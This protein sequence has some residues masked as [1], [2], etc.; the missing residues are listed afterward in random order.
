MQI[1]AKQLEDFNNKEVETL[2][3]KFDNQIDDMDKQLNKQLDKE[4]LIMVSH[5]GKGKEKGLIMVNEAHDDLLK[6]KLKILMSKQFS[7]LTKYLGTM[8]NQVS[9]EHMIR[10]RQIKM[11]FENDKETAIQK[12]LSPDELEST[13]NR[14]AAARDFEIQKSAEQMERDRV[15]RESKTRQDLEEK[16]CQE[17]KDL[18]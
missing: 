9:M 8:Q 16:F 4:I 14:L 10:V 1:E 17:K 13:I 6:R 11:K 5:S 15:D 18:Q 3:N 7:D 2:Q 12:G